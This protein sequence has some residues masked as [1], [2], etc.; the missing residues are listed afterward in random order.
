MISSITGPL[1]L[2]GGCVPNR[3]FMRDVILVELGLWR[4]IAFETF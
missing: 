2:I 4:V 3:H 1:W